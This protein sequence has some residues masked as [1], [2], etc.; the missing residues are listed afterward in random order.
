[1]LS[2]NNGTCQN[3]MISYGEIVK[4]KLIVVQIMCNARCLQ[5]GV[6]PK[7]FQRDAWYRAGFVV[8]LI[9]A[10]GCHCETFCIDN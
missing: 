7:K 4:K 6:S 9:V 1:M 10:S 5:T 2:K 8:E 3:V